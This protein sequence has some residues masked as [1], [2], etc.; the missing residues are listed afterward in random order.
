MKGMR[1]KAFHK[2]RG[3]VITLFLWILLITG[4]TKNDINVSDIVG[5]WV[6]S[7][8]STLVASSRSLARLSFTSD[9]RFEIANLPRRFI[10]R[11]MPRDDFTTA[12]SGFGTWQLGQYDS[13]RSAYRSVELSFDPGILGRF[14]YDTPI[15]ISTEGET[16]LFFWLD[17]AGMG[18]FKLVKEIR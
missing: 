4:C 5:T 13:Y 1:V 7:R 2:E 15:L 16:S 9:G 18:R 8:D 11:S 17:E 10:D 14:G 6:E 12:I 3:I